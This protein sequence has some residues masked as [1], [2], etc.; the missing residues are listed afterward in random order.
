MLV[1]NVG[2]GELPRFLWSVPDGT[3]V[4]VA[5]QEQ[6]LADKDPW[7][8][9][10]LGDKAYYVSILRKGGLRWRR[11]RVLTH[12]RKTHEVVLVGTNGMAEIYLITPKAAQ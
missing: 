5:T 4:Y 9:A 2:V 11:N 3:P 6:L 8:K 7:R 1:D 10:E 12:L